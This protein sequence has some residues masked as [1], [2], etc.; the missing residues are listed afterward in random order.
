MARLG[1]SSPDG[2][3]PS[4]MACLR[5]RGRGKHRQSQGDTRALRGRV[6]AHAKNS[7]RACQLCWRRCVLQSRPA[8]R[9]L[10]LERVTWDAVGPGGGV[11]SKKFA[12]TCTFPEYP[13]AALERR[14][15]SCGA[16][17]PCNTCRTD[18]SETAAV[19]LQVCHTNCAARD[20][21]PSFLTAIFKKGPWQRAN[22]SCPTRVVLASPTRPAAAREFQQSSTNLQ[23][24][25]VCLIG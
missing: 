18:P 12:S 24:L 10:F 3:N 22:T 13:S 19:P 6:W 21:R 17:K 15:G 5:W 11:W 16:R 1:N 2:G 4:R 23:K 14:R 25:Y 9:P 7:R 20:P 8:A